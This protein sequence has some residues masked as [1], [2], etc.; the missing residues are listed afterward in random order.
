MVVKPSA[1]KKGDEQVSEEVPVSVSNGAAT[2]VEAESVNLDETPPKVVGITP[3][4]DTKNGAT[5]L[6]GNDEGSIIG[7][8]GLLPA[9]TSAIDEVYPPHKKVRMTVDE[10]VV[11]ADNDDSKYTNDEVK[12]PLREKKLID[13]RGKLYLAPLTTVGILPFRRVCKRLGADIT[14]GEMAMCTNLLQVR[15][16]VFSSLLLKISIMFTFIPHIRSHFC[17][18]LVFMNL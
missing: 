5:E 1:V 9:D 10:P 16:I 3:I 8:H 13:F 12:E 6:P 17:L 11:D 15:D 2:K 14:C 7:T 18:D 4:P